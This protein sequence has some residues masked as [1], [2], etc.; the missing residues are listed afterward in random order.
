M[1]SDGTKGA[2][3]DVP[4]TSDAQE[5]Y[6]LAP[7]TPA[8]EKK[9]AEELAVM[10]LQCEARNWRVTHR[11][12]RHAVPIEPGLRSL[13]PENGNISDIRWRLSAIPLQPRSISE[14]GDR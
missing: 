8:K 9:T 11:R 13:S 12:V 1:G 5:D 7:A 14:C 6:G 10:I 2:P 3:A 4:T